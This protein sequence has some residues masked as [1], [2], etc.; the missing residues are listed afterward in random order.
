M[1]KHRS[2]GYIVATS[3]ATKIQRYGANSPVSSSI[4]I[5]SSCSTV[6]IV[7]HNKYSTIVN[8][9]LAVG[10]IYHVVLC[11]FQSYKRRMLT[12]WCI[13]MKKRSPCSFYIP[14]QYALIH[15]QFIKGSP[16]RLYLN[17]DVN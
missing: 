14:S 16:T 10:W 8:C 5:R 13:G 15:E 6:C 2:V 12:V 4:T 1:L 9:F 3:Q 11:I 17:A 7:Y